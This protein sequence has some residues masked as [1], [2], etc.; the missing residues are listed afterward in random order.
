[1]AEQETVAGSTNT[2]TG[3][4]SEVSTGEQQ[5]TSGAEEQPVVDGSETP[6]PGEEATG[7]KPDEDGDGDKPKEGDKP[8]EGAPDEYTFEAPE[9]VEYDNELIDAVAPIMKELGLSQEQANKLVDKYTE[10]MSER[11]GDDE[12]MVADAREQWEKSLKEDEKF[13]GDNYEKNAAQVSQ[14][15]QATVP[16]DLKEDL[17]STLNETGL[18]SHPALVK[19]VHHLS[20]Q[21]PTGEDNP[22]GGNPA[23]RGET[24]REKRMY[25]ND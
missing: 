17:I 14:F 19:Y 3:T 4:E 20:K 2:D 1:M 23:P 6:K 7:D 13:G 22:A 16:D 21:F 10:F 5:T 15:I 9:G 25:P 24:S 11:G 12:G 18:G 8:A